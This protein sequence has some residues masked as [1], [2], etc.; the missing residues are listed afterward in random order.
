[1]K[2]FNVCLNVALFA[3]GV[4]LAGTAILLEWR[5]PGGAGRSGMTL[6]GWG[7][8]DWGA[9]HSWLGL[10]M[11]VG[12]IVHLSAHWRWIWR[13]A[14]R[15]RRSVMLAALAAAMLVVGFFAFYPVESAPAEERG[16]FGWRQQ[17]A[18]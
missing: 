7:R 2:R 12:V 4:L 1:M 3:I 16:R 14:A 9:L 5:L 6:L 10:A 17:E 8:H 18:P 11:V 15:Q 13:V